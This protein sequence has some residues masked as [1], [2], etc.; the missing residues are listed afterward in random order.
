[1]F[2][3]CCPNLLAPIVVYATLLIPANILFEAALS[4]LGVG[5]PQSDAVL[6]EELSDAVR[7][8]DL[9]TIARWM[10]LFPGLFLL[11]TTRR[12]TSWVTASGTHSV[13]RSGEQAGSQEGGSGSERP[14]TDEPPT[15]SSKE[16]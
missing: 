8:A 12:S 16:D 9:Y 13:P 4:F 6:G 7:R 11:V 3:R 2:R 14:H 1:M 15:T 5:V 10:M